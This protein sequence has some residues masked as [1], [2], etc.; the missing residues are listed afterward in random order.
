MSKTEPMD[1]CDKAANRMR[2][3]AADLQCFAEQ[4]DGLDGH[5]PGTRAARRLLLD[6]ANDLRAESDRIADAGRL[7][8]LAAYSTMNVK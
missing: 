3:I 5:E 8:F 6:K 1:F 4:W 2:A 7:V